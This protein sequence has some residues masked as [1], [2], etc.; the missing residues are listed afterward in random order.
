M[1]GAWLGLPG[2]HG[3]EKALQKLFQDEQAKAN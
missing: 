2:E 3:P 1:V